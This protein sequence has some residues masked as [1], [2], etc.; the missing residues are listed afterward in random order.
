MTRVQADPSSYLQVRLPAVL[1]STL[2]LLILAG[3]G[4]TGSTPP[5]MAVQ[6]VALSGVVHGGQQPVTQVEHRTFCDEQ[7]RLRRNADPL[8]TTQTETAGNF[9]IT[10][11]IVCP[12]DTT[13]QTYPGVHR[14]ESR[15]DHGNGQ[16]GNLSGGRAGDCRNF[17]ISDLCRDQRS[18]YRCGGVR[19]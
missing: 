7:R 13:S 18:Y 9:N 17:R 1:G 10:A 12:T 15:P 14:R 16:L 2:F 19:V 5:G 11:T 8:A 3:C 4:V 6:N